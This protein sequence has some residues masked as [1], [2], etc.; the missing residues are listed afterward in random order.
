MEKIYRFTQAEL[1]KTV[2]DVVSSM[3][4]TLNEP[5]SPE[6]LASWVAVLSSEE[7]ERFDIALQKSAGLPE[8]QPDE[9]AEEK[10]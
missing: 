1:N 4:V 3:S 5:F 7:R 10:E 9:I 6:T 2:A 8:Q